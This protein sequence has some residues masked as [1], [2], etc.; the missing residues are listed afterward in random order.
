MTTPAG[1]ESTHKPPTQSERNALAADRAR[2]AELKAEIL[3]LELALSSMME[4]DKL[5]QDRLDAYTYPVLILPNEIV[6]EIFVH[7]LPVYP[8]TPP[9]IG[10]TSPNVLSQICRKWRG[11]ALSAPA[12]WRGITLSL[13]N[14]KRLDQKLRLLESWLQRSGSCLLSIKMDFGHDP[15]DNG[16]VGPFT[17]AITAHS[18]RW[19]HLQIH[20]LDLLLPSNIISLPFLRTLST[21]T[22]RNSDTGPL[23]AAPLLRNV[24][25]FLWGEHDI[26]LCPWSQLTTFTANFIPPHHCLYFFTQAVNLVSCSLHIDPKK[27]DHGVQTSRHAVT[28][29]HLQTLILEGSFTSD[30]PWV[31]LDF[32]TLPALQKFQIGARLLQGDPIGLLK[33]LISRSG[34]SIQELYLTRVLVHPPLESYRIALPTVGFISFD[35]IVMDS[36]W[37]VP[38]HEEIEED[39]QGGS[40]DES[41]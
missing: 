13:R 15:V 7:F 4:E 30:V 17:R 28:L 1:A 21:L 22:T 16:A 41:V 32:F 11:I 27:K 25:L 35:G 2:I 29:P 8:K 26:S 33:S 34:C 38:W 31:F 37:H 40:S 3:E 9:V 14:G 6:S 18:I 36:P 19:E 12:L 24:A 23:H 5:L 10:R 20:S 39:D